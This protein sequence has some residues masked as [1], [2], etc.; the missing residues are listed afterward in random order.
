M[1][2]QLARA[3]HV[4]LYATAMTAGLWA[5]QTPTMLIGGPQ[6]HAAIS[7]EARAGERTV[8][9]VERLTER[10]RGTP[11]RPGVRPTFIPRAAIVVAD[12]VPTAVGLDVAL[13]DRAGG[14][15]AWVP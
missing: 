14:I 2:R 5:A 11:A 15:V 7:S 6:S 1:K 12:S 9:L 10:L 13:T 8:D 3:G 4:T